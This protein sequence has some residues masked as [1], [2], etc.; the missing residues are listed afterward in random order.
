MRPKLQLPG[1]GRMRAWLRR[2]G[3]AGRHASHEPTLRAALYSADQMERHGQAL[4]SGHKLGPERSS[5]WLLSRLED[6][7]RVLSRACE[8]LAEA[9]ALGK[10]V[11]P[12]GEWLLDNFYLI[13]EQ[14]RTAQKHLPS[15]Y[16]RELPRLVR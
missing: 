9:A 3:R 2:R 15:G 13:E 7:E 16:S 12:A 6:N 14:I 4:A 1:L 11:P 10:R 5:E 8:L